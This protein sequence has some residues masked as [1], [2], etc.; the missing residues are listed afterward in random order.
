[1]FDYF[2]SQPAKDAAQ[3]RIQGLN[4][5]YG[6]LSDLYGQGAGALTSNT[7]QGIGLYQPLI[8]STQAGSSA[9][10]DASGANGPE[11]L[12]RARA[13]FTATPGYT[14]GINMALNQN[15]AR[16][17]SRGMLG[18]GSTNAAT[19]QLATDY[20][21]Q[22][23]GS[24]V[25]GLQPYLG[26]NQGAVGGAANLYS[27]LGTGLAGLYGQQGQAAQATQ[28]G[29]GNANADAAL[30][31]YNASGNLWKTFGGLAQAAASAYAGIPS[32][33]KPA[34]NPGGTGGN[35]GGVY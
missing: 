2:S 18:S 28:T 27:G 6:Q 34:G 12:A 4:Q 24:Y 7:Q 29:V 15:D 23:Y 11:G 20:A 19:A 21:N 1:L 22:K 5:G 25:Q 33:P 13:N 31:D 9:Y 14:E 35:L 8:Q 32:V 30:A 17:A 3:A 10:A 26:A 16:A